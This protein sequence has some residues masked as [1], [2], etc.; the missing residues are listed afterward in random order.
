MKLDPKLPFG[1]H[2]PPP[3]DHTDADSDFGFGNKITQRLIA[4]DGSFNVVRRGGRKFLA[5]EW[6]LELSWLRFFGLILA[7]Y[8]IVNAFFAG[9]LLLVAGPETIDGLEMGNG[10]VNFLQAFFFSVQTFTTVGYGALN[11]QGLAANLVAS[12]CAL[13]GLL[14]LALVSGLFFAR[15]SR[16]RA[17]ILFSD[18]AVVTPY[19]G[20]RSLQFRI[21]NERNNKIIDL[22]AQVTLSW[23]ENGDDRTLAR[24]RFA[25]LSLERQQVNLFPLNWTIVHPIDEQS[26]LFEFDEQTCEEKR[27]EI[28]VLIEGHD[29]MFSNTVHRSHSYTWDEIEWNR[30]FVP[31]Y[32]PGPTGATVLELK[33]ISET[34]ELPPEDQS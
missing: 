6:L 10:G 34:T 28:L 22:M 18:S 33:K 8:I 20:G 26:P 5:Y 3:A 14:S 4:P 31:M 32:F 1:N 16:P 2:A 21:A 19:N 25:N 12:L 30:R 7:F 23:V 17:R 13:S 11:P 9:L 27:L 15:F 29:E 24:R